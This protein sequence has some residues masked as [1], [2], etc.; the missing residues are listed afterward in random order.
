[1][2]NIVH[3][4]LR[5]CVQATPD[6]NPMKI[7]AVIVAEYDVT[8]QHQQHIDDV[9]LE[10]LCMIQLPYFDVPG[11]FA[12]SAVAVSDCGEWRSSHFTVRNAWDSMH[13]DT[14]PSPSM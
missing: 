9:H 2:R 1:M 11:S 12:V 13:A 7:P 5:A 10:L 6:P 14:L 8:Q 4:L 3:Q